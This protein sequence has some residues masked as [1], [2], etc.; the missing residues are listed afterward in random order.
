LFH[1]PSQLFNFAPLVISCGDV[2]CSTFYLYSLDCLSCGNVICGTF[3]VCLVTY[4]TINTIHTIVRIIDGSI[5]PLIIF[6]ALT[7]VFSYSLF[8]PE[9]KAPPSSTLFFL[10]KTLLEN[11][12]Q[13]SLYFPMLSTSL[14]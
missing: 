11:M 9:P 1:V 12:L 10:L 4:I 13:P 14:P 3:E 7:Y 2:I 6:C 5:L 8:I